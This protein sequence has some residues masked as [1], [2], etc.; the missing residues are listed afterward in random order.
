M[1]SAKS[2]VSVIASRKAGSPIGSLAR[3]PLAFVQT[4]AFARPGTLYPFSVERQAFFDWRG[5]G[6][7]EAKGGGPL[8]GAADEQ[9]EA[10]EQSG[11]AR[12]ADAQ[13]EGR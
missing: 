13:A 8:L 9:G 3:S 5:A 12:R 1:P 4:T 10:R 11:A 7:V 2:S 6:V